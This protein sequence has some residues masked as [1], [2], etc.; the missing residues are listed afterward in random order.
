MEKGKISDEITPRTVNETLATTTRYA[1][2]SKAREDLCAFLN[3]DVGLAEMIKGVVGIEKNVE[4]LKDVTH[5]DMKESTYKN[6]QYLKMQVGEANHMI[7]QLVMKSEQREIREQEMFKQL[8][9]VIAYLTELKPSTKSNE[10]AIIKKATKALQKELE[11]CREEKKDRDYEIIDLQAVNRKL[12]GEKAAISKEKRA[13]QK[14]F[15]KKWHAFTT[16]CTCAFSK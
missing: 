7:K 8:T 13:L 15:D 16:K 1:S 5:Q 3:E 11:Q 6:A 4:E 14:D 10:D 9:E 2:E 12:V